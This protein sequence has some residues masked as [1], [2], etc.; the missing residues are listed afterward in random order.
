MRFAR[1]KLWACF[2]QCIL[3]KGASLVPVVWKRLASD[4]G[5]YRQAGMHADGGGLYLRVT[6]TTSRQLNKSS[7]Y[8]YSVGGRERQMALG[9]LTEV[10]LADARQK[11]WCAEVAKVRTR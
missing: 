11:V 2:A 5:T 6:R 4:C 8:R 7:L 10:K 1:S 9:P 3:S